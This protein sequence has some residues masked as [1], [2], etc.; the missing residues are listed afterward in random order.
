MSAGHSVFIIKSWLWR[1]AMTML[2]PM[3]L[4]GVEMWEV[5]ILIGWILDAVRYVVVGIQGSINRGLL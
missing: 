5:G 3:P 1:D 2:A 4:R